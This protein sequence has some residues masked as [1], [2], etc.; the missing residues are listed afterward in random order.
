VRSLISIQD[1][2]HEDLYH[3]FSLASRFEGKQLNIAN[4]KILATVFFEPSTRTRL[5]FETA[6]KRLG[7]DVISLGS[8]ESSSVAKGESLLDT[9]KTI[10]CYADIIVLRH[11]LEGSARF[12]AERVNIPVINGGDGANQHPTQTLIDLYT[13]KKLRGD[14]KNLKIA[15]FGD[16]K[17]A[18]TMRSLLTGLS[19]LDEQMT[20][21]LI[22]PKAL[23]MQTDVL[24]KISTKLQIIQTNDPKAIKENNC[25][26]VYVCRIQ[27]ERFSDPTEAEKIAEKFRV[28]KEMIGDAM[29]LHPLPKLDEISPEI[30]KSPQAKYFEQVANG[31]LIR[32]AI[33]AKLLELTK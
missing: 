14:F 6:M 1:L 16:L 21:V 8:K 12:V 15:L 2:S 25:E 30:D 23:E 26:F 27:K 32:M 31:V 17:H 9:V 28:R 18:R 29:V 10:A 4:G 11:P 13:I 24:S 7:G 20:V 22:S 19:I 3:F 33:L 5:S